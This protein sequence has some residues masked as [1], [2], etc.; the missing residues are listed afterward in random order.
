MK[1]YFVFTWR[2][3]LF[4]YHISCGLFQIDKEIVLQFRQKL[5][6]VESERRLCYA[7]TRIE[8]PATNECTHVRLPLF[9]YRNDSLISC[10]AQN[11]RKRSA[12]KKRIHSISV[13]NFEFVYYTTLLPVLFTVSQIFST[14]AAIKTN[15]SALPPVPPTF[16]TITATTFF[17]A[18]YVPYLY[19]SNNFI[20]YLLNEMFSVHHNRR[21]H[22]K[23]L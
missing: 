19:L 23:G 10:V 9:E 20:I 5:S 12:R 8:W 21:I 16:P 7:R 13:Y 14:M 4:Y 17:A 11:G 6:L 18:N 22:L 1:V 15:I 3:T 2:R